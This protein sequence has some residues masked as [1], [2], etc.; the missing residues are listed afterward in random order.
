[1]T[2]L[3][4][5]KSSIK[6]TK[7]AFDQ[8]WYG[9]PKNVQ[10]NL[11]GWQGRRFLS[12]SWHEYIKCPKCGSD[13][14]QRLF[15]AAI[16]EIEELSVKKLIKDKRVL[17]FAPESAISQLLCN[18]AARYVTADFLRTDCDF[19]LDLSDMPEMKDASFE[20]VIAFDVLEHVPDHQKA[21]YEIHRVLSHGGW[22]IFTVPQKDNLKVTLE[23]PTIV[24]R[25]DRE[26]HYGQW[27]HLRIFGDDFSTDL[28][29]AGFKVKIVDESFFS[30]QVTR[31]NVL[32][33]SV[34]STH[35]LAT[36]YRKVFFAQ[37]V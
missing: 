7:S 34:L 19:S 11:C 9:Y 32:F 10:C 23:D 16:R 21:I 29:R 20:V 28:E 6:K 31:K 26:K 24:T 37:K 13:I 3:S 18:L 1:M 30:L 36:N 22:G 4:I 2:F 17:H 35:P 27:D 15:I 12:D 33:P 5:A 8:F 14:R 25:E